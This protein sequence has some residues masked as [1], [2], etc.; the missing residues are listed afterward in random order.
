MRTED[1]GNQMSAA[2]RMPVQASNA[3][4]PCG[5]KNEGGEAAITPA[6]YTSRQDGGQQRR[7]QRQMRSR[8]RH[9]RP[10][11]WETTR[12]TAAGKEKAAQSLRCAARGGKVLEPVNRPGKEKMST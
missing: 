10:L 9:T 8:R 1:A 2:G 11:R 7:R 5:G 6:V 4:T 12:Y 3:R